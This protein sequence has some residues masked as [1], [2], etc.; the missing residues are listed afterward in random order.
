MALGYREN[1]LTALA[2]EDGHTRGRG[3]L[4]SSWID[5]I[6]VES[7]RDDSQQNR[8]RAGRP[9][10]GL[11]PLTRR[12]VDM[13]PAEIQKRPTQDG[14]SRSRSLATPASCHRI[15]NNGVVAVAEGHPWAC[16]C[17]HNE[18]LRVRDR[19]CVPH[20]AAYPKINESPILYL[21]ARQKYLDMILSCC[22]ESS[23]SSDRFGITS[24]NPFP[25]AEELEFLIQNGKV[26]SSAVKESAAHVCHMIDVALET[27][28]S[29][30]ETMLERQQTLHSLYCVLTLFVS[31][32][33]H[34]CFEIMMVDQDLLGL[35]RRFCSVAC[36]SRS[37]EAV[38]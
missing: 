35:Y 22:A 4:I 28:E 2:Q 31:L 11:T 26:E 34:R 24:H 29:L 38:H 32:P 30:E 15:L 5:N 21:D 36:V 1:D 19:T 8:D 12:A 17:S 3:A 27:T 18:H 33:T 16:A 10:R 37:L 7:S 23:Y 9:A 13:L 14:I 20:P 6:G 25:Q